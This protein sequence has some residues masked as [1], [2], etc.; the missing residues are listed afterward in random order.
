MRTDT[1]VKEEG[2]AH[3]VIEQKGRNAWNFVEKSNSDSPLAYKNTASGP[4]MMPHLSFFPL[5]A[6]ISITPFYFHAHYKE[7]QWARI[8]M[9]F[10]VF[11]KTLATMPSKRLI[12]NKVC[13]SRAVRIYIESSLY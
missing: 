2:N 4:L 10:L 3:A 7:Q 1:N 5:L 13:S 8:I 6:F 9:P 12:A 11:P